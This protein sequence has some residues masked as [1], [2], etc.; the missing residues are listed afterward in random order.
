MELRRRII[1]AALLLAGILAISVLGYRIL[2][3][4]DV[5]F[6]NALYMAIITLA[7]VGYGEFVDTSHN[8]A[9]RVFNMFVVIFGVMIT[10]YVF[11]SVT[12]FLVEGDYS[13]AFRRRK[14][15]KRSVVPALRPDGPS[16]SARRT[17]GRAGSCPAA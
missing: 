12:A 14:M 8:P 7:G 17:P 9:L 16:T 5:G 13:N 2:G 3:G 10:A 11:S 6:L 4:H 15:L 1:T